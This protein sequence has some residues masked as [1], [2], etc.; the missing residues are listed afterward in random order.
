MYGPWTANGVSH[1]KIGRLRGAPLM[2]SSDIR[3]MTSV[4]KSFGRRPK[5]RGTPLAQIR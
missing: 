5:E 2:A 4:E 1:A 3:V